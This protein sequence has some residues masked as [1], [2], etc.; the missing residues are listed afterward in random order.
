MGQGPVRR[1]GHARQAPNLSEAVNGLLAEFAAAREA[2]ARAAGARIAASIA[3]SNAVI[4]AHG[5]L[6]DEHPTR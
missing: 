2:E 4:E 1:A 6:G 5:A 3:A